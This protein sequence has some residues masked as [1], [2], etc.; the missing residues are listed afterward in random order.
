MQSGFTTKSKRVT[1]EFV[2]TQLLYWR[3][4]WIKKKCIFSAIDF[5]WAFDSVNRK[6]LMEV[7][8]EYKIDSKTI[9]KIANIYAKDSS[10]ITSKL[11]QKSLLR[12][13]V[14][15]DSDAHASQSCSHVDNTKL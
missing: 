1:R 4:L 9:D 8:M 11:S 5:T 2:N 15:L 10:N 7:L 13:Q 6:R 12:S 3:M 14:A